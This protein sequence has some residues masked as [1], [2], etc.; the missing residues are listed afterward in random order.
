MLETSTK[1]KYAKNLMNNQNIIFVLSFPYGKTR[2]I[3]KNKQYILMRA[4]LSNKIV[5][6]I[7]TKINNSIATKLRVALINT[8]IIFLEYFKCT[9]QYND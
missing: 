1:S 4:L 8:L 5:F 6:W 7:F 9:S 2:K 3:V